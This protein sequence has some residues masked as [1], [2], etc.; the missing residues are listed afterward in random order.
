MPKVSVIIPT[1]NCADY[2]EDAIDSVLKQT[3]INFELIVV[4]DGSTD[5]TYA[6]IKTYG[7]KIRYIYQ[8]N[9]GL[10][11][12]RNTGIKNC[13]GELVAFLDADDLWLPNK[14]ELQNK[15]FDDYSSVGLV[16]GDIR[17]LRE[18][19]GVLTIPYRYSSTKKY[20]EK[21]SGNIFQPVFYRH[22][23]ISCPTVIVRKD[24]ITEVGLFD[25]KLTR[26]GFE[27][28]DMWLRILQHY[29]AYYIN[30]PLA[31]YRVRNDSMSKN[32]KK[33]LKAQKYVIDKLSRKYNLGILAMIRA[34]LSMINEWTIRWFS[35]LFYQRILK[36]YNS[37]TFTI[38]KRYGI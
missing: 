10:A 36:I 26:L 23:Y 13:T 3:F 25:E 38:R 29:E 16:H 30:K 1:Y 27:D 17:L 31:V 8:K 12:A 32:R 15:I 11:V 7:A 14:L 2:V 37:D 24:A 34:Y 33:M 22:I 21:H 28:F 35:I 6:K 9:S 5:D 18:E 4:D 19:T 20:L